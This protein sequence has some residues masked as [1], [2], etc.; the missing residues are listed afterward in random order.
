MSKEPLICSALE[1]SIYDYFGIGKKGKHLWN[2]FLPC[3]LNP[4]HV[5]LAPIPDKASCGAFGF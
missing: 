1:M 2:N 5:S 3:M 4:D